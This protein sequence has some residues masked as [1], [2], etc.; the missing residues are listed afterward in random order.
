MFLIFGR[1]L[2]HFVL[3]LIGIQD[4]AFDPAGESE[5]IESAAIHVPQA[6]AQRFLAHGAGPIF[7][8]ILHIPAQMTYIVLEILLQVGKRLQNTD[9]RIL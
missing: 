5:A 2:R 8:K 6:A 7:Q 3:V 9:H 4:G 1:I